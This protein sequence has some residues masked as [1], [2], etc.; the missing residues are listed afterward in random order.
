MARKSLLFFSLYTFMGLLI[1]TFRSSVILILLVACLC[2]HFADVI[3]SHLDI[4]FHR[5]FNWHFILQI[6]FET[7]FICVHFS[8]A[9]KFKIINGILNE[10]L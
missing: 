1:P 2:V 9:L 4:L 5:F 6:F 8:Q 10:V 7:L 3:Q